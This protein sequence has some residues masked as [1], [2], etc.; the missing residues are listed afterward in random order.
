MKQAMSSEELKELLTFDKPELKVIDVRSPDEYYQRHLAFAENLPASEL[1]NRAQD[2]LKMTDM[3]V[4]V[5]NKGH[6]RSQGVADR[7]IAMGYQNVFYLEEGMFG[8]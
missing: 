8:W 2:R 5:C 4:C 7:L 6:E 1:E 3:I